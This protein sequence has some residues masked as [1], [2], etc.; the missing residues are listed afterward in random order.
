MVVISVQVE[1]V[2]STAVCQLFDEFLRL[3]IKKMMVVY[4]QQKLTEL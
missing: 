4:L 3:Q 2:E 1:F